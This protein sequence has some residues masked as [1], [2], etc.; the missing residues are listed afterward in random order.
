ML[1]EVKLTGC[2]CDNCGRPLTTSGKRSD[3]PMY[4][5]RGII[6][7][8]LAKGKIKWHTDINEASAQRGD[9]DKH[10]CEDCYN[11]AFK[12]DI[13]LTWID[14]T[15]ENLPREG[16]QVELFTNRREH[17]FAKYSKGN[18]YPLKKVLPSGEIEYDS[19]CFTLFVAMWRDNQKALNLCQ[20]S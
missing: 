9:N 19:R 20:N 16:Q 2:I 1:I 12:E 6:Q 7:Y 11:P 5:S 8:C 18:F 15:Q 4:E 14:Y 3:L 10:Y 17:V 13:R